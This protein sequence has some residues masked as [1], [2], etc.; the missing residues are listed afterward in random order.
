MSKKITVIVCAI[1]ILISGCGGGS[2]FK[3]DKITEKW[4]L[5][6]E[7]ALG[8]SPPPVA[9]TI[10]IPEVITKGYSLETGSPVA[11]RALPKQSVTIRIL[12]SDVKTVLRALSRAANQ[13]ILMKEDIKGEVN[14]D[15]K[16]VPWDEVFRS[17]LR[18]RG[19]SYEWDGNIIRVL[20]PDDKKAE[21]LVTT[22]VPINYADIKQVRENLAD[23]ISKDEKNIP[24]GTVKID[25]HSSTVIIRASRDDIARM[26]PAIEKVDVPR[27]QIM[28]KAN[29]VEATKTA[30]RNL[31]VQWG[32]VYGNKA[33]GQ[34]YYITPGG[35]QGGGSSTSISL[36]TDP[37]SYIP[38]ASSSGFGSTGI[39][40]QGF[41]TNFPISSS[42]IQAAGGLGLLV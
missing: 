1:L 22:V 3:K 16:N 7:D 21:P 28:I 14:L 37:N 25:E 35:T 24:Q 36:P 30:A 42:A 34:N 20:S 5:K 31:G 27:P 19:L 41:A 32:G 38:T 33:G 13:N 6:A 18:S 8:S 26:I 12:K 4:S 11:T 23:F 2:D 29:I 10:E 17:V 9:R 15:V 39:S 40:G